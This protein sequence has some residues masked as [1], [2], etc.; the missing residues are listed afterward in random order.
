MPSLATVGGLV[1][2]LTWLAGPPTPDPEHGTQDPS[3]FEPRRSDPR[4]SGYALPPRRL[5]FEGLLIQLRASNALVRVFGLDRP[6]AYGLDLALAFEARYWGGAVGFALRPQAGYAFVHHGEFD[7]HAALTGLGLCLLPVE[8]LGLCYTPNLVVGSEAG[9]AL[10]GVRH[11][12]SLE[13]PRTHF[14]ALEAQHGLSWVGPAGPRHELR[15][16]LTFDLMFPI[17]TLV[18]LSP[19]MRM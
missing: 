11:G 15:G 6:H 8:V 19:V 3:R 9:A 7:S 17:M 13:L 5:A 10:V 16:V 18:N 1:S 12:L 2:A 14:V 4:A